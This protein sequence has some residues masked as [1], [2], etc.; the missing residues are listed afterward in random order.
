MTMLISTQGGGLEMAPRGEATPTPWGSIETL[1]R[2]GDPWSHPNG[3]R[4]ESRPTVR[5]PY[6][7]AGRRLRGPRAGEVFALPPKGTDLAPE[8]QN[9]GTHGTPGRP[10]PR[11]KW[12]KS[13]KSSR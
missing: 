1:L 13:G 4:R 11:E 6:R 8:G 2:R 7:A 3:R 12:T 9:G 10:T 5:T